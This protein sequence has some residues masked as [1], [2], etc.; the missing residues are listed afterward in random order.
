MIQ[1]AGDTL[2]VQH[3][4]KCSVQQYVEVEVQMQEWKKYIYKLQL[5]H[6]L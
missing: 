4:H 6:T 3:K 1:A 2:S 5:K